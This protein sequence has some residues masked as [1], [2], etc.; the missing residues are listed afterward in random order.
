MPVSLASFD[1]SFRSGR[2][3]PATRVGHVL[4]AA[5]ISGD[6]IDF[7]C[8]SAEAFEVG[9]LAR[10]P[11]AGMTVSLLFFQPSTRTRL[12]FE[13]ATVALGCHAIGMDDMANSRSNKRTGESLEDAGA[14]ISNLSDAIVIRH[15]EVGAAERLASR[16][17]KP[18]I[19]AGD[20][21]NEHPTQALVDVFSL[22]RGLDGIRGKTLGFGGDPRGRTVRSLVLLLRHERPAELLFCPPA[23]VGIPQDVLAIMM[24][25]QIR[26]RVITDISVALRHCDALMMAPYDMSDIGEAANSG[27]ISP[28]V[29]PESHVVTAE[30]IIACNSETLLYH[31]L[32]RQDEIDVSCDDLPNALYFEQVRLSKFMRMAILERALV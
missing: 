15:H 4:S 11:A 2:F 10:S 30:K 21:W 26:Y 5:A 12:G 13:A 27:Y 20:G 18:V 1:T 24:E 19:N 29:T 9:G 17:R 7:L 31:P 28:R 32:P 22:R 14:V 8:D 6:D 3:R 25:H 23:H 16:S